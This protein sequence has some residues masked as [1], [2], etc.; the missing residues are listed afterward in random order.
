MLYWFVHTFPFSYHT[1]LTLSEAAITGSLPTLKSLI[2]RK[3]DTDYSSGPIQITRGTL[4]GSNVLNS[5]KGSHIRLYDMPSS[6][7]QTKVYT[8]Y[9]SDEA[10][11]KGDSESNIGVITKEQEISVSSQGA[12]GKEHERSIEI[13]HHGC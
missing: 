13:F 7:V 1:L 12:S 11:H 4:G 2:R 5:T 9:G 8:G 3:G 6:G 10:L